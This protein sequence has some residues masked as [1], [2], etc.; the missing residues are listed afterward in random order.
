MNGV[1]ELLDSVYQLGTQH[2]NLPFRLC[3]VRIDYVMGWVKPCFVVAP[4]VDIVYYL[5]FLP[6][7]IRVILPVLLSALLSVC[8]PSCAPAFAPI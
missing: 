4:C 3:N 8:L 7:P 5:S 1:R 6:C 2:I